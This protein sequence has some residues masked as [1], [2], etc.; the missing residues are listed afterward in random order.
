MVL[1]KKIV[2]MSHHLHMKDLSMR[3]R[4]LHLYAFFFVFWMVGLH[5]HPHDYLL[6]LLFLLPPLLLLP[7]LLP[8]PS[9]SSPPLLPQ[10]SLLLHHLLLLLE[11][12]FLFHY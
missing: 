6:P 11:M 1:I 10:L 9:G 8:S 12:F 4:N 5:H 3:W 7:S 2:M